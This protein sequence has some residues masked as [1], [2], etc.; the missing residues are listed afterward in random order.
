VTATSLTKS[1]AGAFSFDNALTAGNVTLSGGVTTVSG[2]GSLTATSIAN[3]AALVIASSGTQTLAAMSGTG[4]LAEAGR[5]GG[6]E[7]P[8][9]VASAAAGSGPVWMRRDDSDSSQVT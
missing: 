4:S 3:D 6:R 2:T 5:G 7:C 8:Q 9:E 1:A